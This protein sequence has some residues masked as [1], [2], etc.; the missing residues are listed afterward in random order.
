MNFLSISAL[1]AFLAVIGYSDLVF[2]DDDDE[3]L[4][5]CGSAIKLTHVE[6]GGK[7]YL[8]SAGMSL[9]SG[10]GQQIVTAIPDRTQGSAL[11]IIKESAL[12]KEPCL[13]GAKLTCGSKIRLTHKTTNRNLHSHP[14][15]SP[16]SNQQEVSAFGDN[17]EGDEGDDW[18]ILCKKNSNKYLQRGE[19]IYL[20]HAGTKKFL[21]ASNQVKFSQSNC[22]HRC[23]VLNHLEVFARAKSDQ[24]TEWFIDVGIFL[25]Q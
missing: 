3:I 10:S 18:I 23:P 17:G 14:I 25:S 11:W 7:H 22:G 9:G 1:Y 16:L 21:G 4:I 5:G 20:Q 6:S 19:R 12:S 8:N 13:S 15:R 2:A 24:M